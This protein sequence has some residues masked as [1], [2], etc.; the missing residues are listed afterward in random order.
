MPLPLP[1]DANCSPQIVLPAHFEL[2]EPYDGSMP[3]KPMPAQGQS[4]LY[5]FVPAM[6]TQALRGVS[7]LSWPSPLAT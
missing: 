4:R 3:T 2:K 7:R 1:G 6:W 5:L